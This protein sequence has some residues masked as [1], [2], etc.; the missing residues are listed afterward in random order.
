MSQNTI[1]SE[2]YS[3]IFAAIEDILAGHP[4]LHGGRKNCDEFFTTS[5]KARVCFRLQRL[6][7]TAE[8]GEKK[9]TYIKFWLKFNNRKLM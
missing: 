2:D 9:T 8:A 5:L 4:I 3:T 7:Q 1:D 6:Q